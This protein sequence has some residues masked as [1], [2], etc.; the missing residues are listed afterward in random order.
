MEAGNAALR[1]STNTEYRPAESGAA[2]CS[3]CKGT[4]RVECDACKG[5]GDYLDRHGKPQDC[6]ECFGRGWRRCTAFRCVNGRVRR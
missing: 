3:D 1:Q 5:R 2:I 4:G 6:T